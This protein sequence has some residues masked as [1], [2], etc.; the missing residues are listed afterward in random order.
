M[1]KQIKWDLPMSKETKGTR[2][3]KDPENQK[4]MVYVPKDEIAKLGDP[5]S[6]TVTITAKE[7]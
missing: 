6:I 7:D 3:Y 5:E 2:Q 1:A 4:H